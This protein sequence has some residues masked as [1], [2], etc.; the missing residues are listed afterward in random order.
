MMAIG[1]C[2]SGRQRVLDARVA[3]QHFALS[4]AGR[5]GQAIDL[6][7]QPREDTIWDGKSW[8]LVERQSVGKSLKSSCSA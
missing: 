3:D 2:I 1:A 5:D 7:D 8:N 6:P 4:L